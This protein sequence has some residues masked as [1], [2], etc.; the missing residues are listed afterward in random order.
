MALARAGA[1]PRRA[2]VAS[3]ARPTAL[4][5]PGRFVQPSPSGSVGGPTPGDFSQVLGTLRSPREGP[6]PG[7]LGRAA[8]FGGRC[9]LFCVIPTSSCPAVLEY[10]Y[11]NV[12]HPDIMLPIDASAPLPPGSRPLP[13]RAVGD[14]CGERFGAFFLR[15][16]L[17]GR[18]SGVFLDRGCLSA[19]RAWQPGPSFHP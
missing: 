8:C 5:L 11:E 12:V 2:P 16:R 13:P 10:S 18:G 3:P 14:G 9:V 17:H 1:C 15:M 7:P 4:S 19:P 6:S